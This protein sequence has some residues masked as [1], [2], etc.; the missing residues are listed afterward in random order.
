MWN[1]CISGKLQNESFLCYSSEKF[2]FARPFD[3]A[4]EVSYFKSQPLVKN[5]G[6]GSKDVPCRKWQKKGQGRKISCSNCTVM[7]VLEEIGDS[8]V[9]LQLLPKI[10]FSFNWAAKGFI[11]GFQG[12]HRFVAKVELELVWKGIDDLKIPIEIHF[13]TKAERLNWNW[14]EN[15]LVSSFT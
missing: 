8:K 14:Y 9:L 5:I 15:K 6:T 4:V 3:Q 12:F 1:R 10:Y 11:L 2:K 13:I 7:L